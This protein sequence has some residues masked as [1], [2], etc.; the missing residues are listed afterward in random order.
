MSGDITSYLAL[1]TSEHDDKPNFLATLSA[2]VQPAADNVSLL[3]SL[4]QA[5]DLDVAVGVQLDAAGEWVGRSRYLTIPLTGVYFSL[6]IAGVGFDQGAW[7]G[8]YDP[9]S[10]LTALHDDA[11]RTLLRAK[12]L[13]N[14]WDGTIPDA[15][16]AW[17]VVFGSTGYQ[18]IIEDFCDMTMLIGLVGNILDA[19]TMAL[20]TGG[21][22]SLRPAG[23][24]ITAYAFPTVANTPLFGF[25]VENINIAGFE[26]G[27]F[28]QILAPTS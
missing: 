25:D 26:V 20:L 24:R 14:K 2:L 11:Y 28:A 15:Y 19:V 7:L 3:A 13:A 22:L 5:F 1:V 23:V 16:A 17:A 8:P 9:V 18:V 12:I 4:V 10:G 6:D 21:Y 27:G